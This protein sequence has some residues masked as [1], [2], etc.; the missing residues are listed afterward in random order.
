MA[1]FEADVAAAESLRERLYS[2]ELLQAVTDELQPREPVA[3]V[4]AQRDSRVAQLEREQHDR[5][6]VAAIPIPRMGPRLW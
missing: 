1:S 2:S 5:Q 3:T 6:A 4:S